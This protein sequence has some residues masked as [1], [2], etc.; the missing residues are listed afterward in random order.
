VSDKGLKLL[1]AGS[2]APAAVARK[3]EEE[4]HSLK[5]NSVSAPDPHSMV[6]WSRIQEV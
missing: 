2:G 6:A 4:I 1:V 3:E 5:K